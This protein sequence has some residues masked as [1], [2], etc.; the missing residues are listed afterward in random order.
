MDVVK[1][2]FVGAVATLAMLTV[3]SRPSIGRAQ[4]SVFAIPPDRPQAWMGIGGGNGLQ[5]VSRAARRSPSAADTLPRS[6]W[7]NL[8]DEASRR[9]GIPAEWVRG[10]MRVES[11]GRELLNGRPTTSSAGAM[12]LMQV[13]PKT[14]A[15]L[16]LRYGLGANPYD[17]RAN[18]L[19]GTAYLREL[20]DRFGPDHF[21]AAYNAGPGRITDHIRTGRSLPEE[22]RRYVR[23]LA[24]RLI[25]DGASNAPENSETVRDLTSLE[26]LRDA[27]HLSFRRVTTSPSTPRTSPIIATSTWVGSAR[28]QSVNAHEAHGLFVTLTRPDRSPQQHDL[29]GGDD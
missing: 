20:Y 23:M 12:G 18:I 7:D 16:A 2:S 29:D 24:P 8:I 13:M 22:T 27:A 4:T 11:R 9:F 28:D 6:R 1:A 15:E 10:V 3:V 19:A 21:L 17:P 5:S 14:F 26:A 25:V